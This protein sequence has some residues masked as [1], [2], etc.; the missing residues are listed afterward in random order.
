MLNITTDIWSRS[1]E[2]L[3]H[4]ITLYIINK[5]CV[6]LRMVYSNIIFSCKCIHAHIPK[7]IVK[8]FIINYV[9]KHTLIHTLIHV[10]T[11]TE[12]TIRSSE[13]CQCIWMDRMSICVIR[14]YV[15]G[16]LSTIVM[17]LILGEPICAR[18]GWLVELI[19][20]LKYS[21]SS[22]VLSSKVGTIKVAYIWPELKLTV[23]GPPS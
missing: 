11:I 2:P 18:S 7:C 4:H 23:Y 1:H 10:H 9:C 21:D 5:C 12:V 15:P 16:S 13:I 3:S 22:V 6:C 17:K 19:T 20:T 8:C 14:M